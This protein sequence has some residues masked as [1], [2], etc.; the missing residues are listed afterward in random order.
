LEGCGIEA[1]TGA[2]SRNSLQGQPDN[3]IALSPY[4]VYVHL[5]GDYGPHKLVKLCEEDGDLRVSMD[6]GQQRLLWDQHGDAPLP[7]SQVEP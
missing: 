6:L 3:I 4:V 1:F 5:D 7:S 2:G